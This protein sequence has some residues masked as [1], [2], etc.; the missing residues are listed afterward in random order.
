MN[1]SLYI[2]IY[3]YIYSILYTIRLYVYTIPTIVCQFHFGARTGVY[4]SIRS[5]YYYIVSIRMESEGEFFLRRFC[6]VS[7]TPSGAF[8][9]SVSVN[10]KFHPCEER[11]KSPVNR[12][13]KQ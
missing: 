8:S 12:T 9:K 5:I 1:H 4:I 2:Y 3:I 13:E 6:N 11:K 10:I 7:A